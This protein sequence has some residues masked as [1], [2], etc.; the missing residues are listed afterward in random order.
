[1]TIETLLSPIELL[2]ERKAARKAVRRASIRPG[3]PIRL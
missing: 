1:M 3:Q 2:A